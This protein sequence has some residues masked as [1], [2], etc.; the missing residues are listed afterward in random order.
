MAPR[1]GTMN[2]RRQKAE[3]CS[4][5]SCVTT[6]KG[7]GSG[8]ACG[9]G[10]A[11]EEP[12][13]TRAPQPWCVHLPVHP[14]ILHFKSLPPQSTHSSA[15][16]H[17][18]L[19]THLHGPSGSVLLPSSGFLAAVPP[20]VTLEVGLTHGSAHTLLLHSHHPPCRAPHSHGS[21]HR[22]GS[23]WVRN[24]RPAPFWPPLPTP[25]QHRGRQH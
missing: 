19:E 9:T 13:S 24:S 22:A 2:V 6:G 23:H 7:W 25:L 21:S 8:R 17:F 18:Q 16:C 20:A 3:Q 10:K 14:I 15:H 12:R 1:A 5:W 4:L 11:I